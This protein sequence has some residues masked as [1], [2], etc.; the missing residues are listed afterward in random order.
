MA[1]KLTPGKIQNLKA[2]TNDRGIIAAAAMDQ[3]GSLKKAIGAAKGIDPGDVTDE[4]L[5][6]VA[7]LKG[8][9]SLSLRNNGKI[10]TRGIRHL[11]KMTSL[12]KLILKSTNITDDGLLALAALKLKR[13]GLSG[14]PKITDKGM[15]H[16]TK[17]KT[18]RELCAPDPP[19]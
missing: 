5:A 17:I 4:M 3:R 15:A 13:L 11:S 9:Q 16:L 8:I 1:T 2:L 6:N 18:L 10:T 7:S 12:R 14:C 19:N